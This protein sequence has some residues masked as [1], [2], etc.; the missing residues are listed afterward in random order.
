MIW[1]LKL[2]H[3]YNLGCK[4]HVQIVDGTIVS[5]QGNGYVKI[6][7][8]LTLDGVLYVPECTSNLISG[9][10]LVDSKFLSVVFDS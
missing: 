7:N 3:N 2:L 1:N 8:K 6:T 5:A 10:S 9:S 4:S